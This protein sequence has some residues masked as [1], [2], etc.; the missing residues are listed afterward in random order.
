MKNKTH[1]NLDKSHLWFYRNR[2]KK[3][4]KGREFSGSRECTVEQIDV[5]GACRRL[6]SPELGINSLK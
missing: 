2:K 5:R 4:K 1:T 3:E 6:R